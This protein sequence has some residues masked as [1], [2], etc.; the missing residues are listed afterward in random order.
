[1]HKQGGTCPGVPTCFIFTKW[2]EKEAKGGGWD[3]T[4]DPVN[5]DMWTVVSKK[6]KPVNIINQSIDIYRAYCAP[7]TAGS[8]QDAVGNGT[9]AKA[10]LSL[11]WQIQAIDLYAD[12]YNKVGKGEGLWE[13]TAEDSSSLRDQESSLR[14]LERQPCRTKGLGLLIENTEQGRTQDRLWYSQDKLECV[15]KK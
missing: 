11:Q 9:D 2:E 4:G 13:W 3:K 12:A 15:S 7:S 6:Q 14:R 10:W 5:I 8:S 1:M